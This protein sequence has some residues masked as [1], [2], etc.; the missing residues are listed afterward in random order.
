MLFFQVQKPV[1]Q[2]QRMC[3]L[4]I[5][6]RH[7][8]KKDCDKKKFSEHLGFLKLISQNTT[9]K[10]PFPFLLYEMYIIELIFAKTIQWRK[11]NLFNKRC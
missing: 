1:E 7:S 5:L 10:K 9:N 8:S 6:F 4:F 2:N 11:D 3:F